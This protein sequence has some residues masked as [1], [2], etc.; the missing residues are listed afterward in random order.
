MYR[1]VTSFVLLGMAAVASSAIQDAEKLYNRTDYHGALGLLLPAANKDAKTWALIGQ[2]YFG[3]AEF[4]KA[5]EAFEKANAL[6]PG[7]S[8]YAHWLGKSWGRRAEVAPV[9][10]AP[11]YA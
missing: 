1:V 8:E 10:L 11:G 3:M 5:T 6:N 7:N 4:K 9:F 2:S